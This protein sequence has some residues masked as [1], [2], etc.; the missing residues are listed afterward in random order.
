[1]S[2]QDQPGKE[3]FRDLIRQTGTGREEPERA[4]RFHDTGRRVPR[5]FTGVAATT[6]NTRNEFMRPGVQ[7]KEMRRL[8]QGKFHVDD[9][10]RIDLHGLTRD[11]AH[12]ALN[13]FIDRCIIKGIRRAC[14]ICGK[15]LHSRAG[16]S[17]LGSAVRNWL[18]QYHKVLAY[19]TAQLKDG[20]GGAL[21]ILL[22]TGRA[23]DRQ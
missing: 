7:H 17:V 8:K 22:K 10:R 9:D 18:E 4:P 15:G 3:T 20:G 13:E 21:Y 23:R 5:P 12:Q 2:E 19:C 11:E 6:E 1:M 16:K 14:V